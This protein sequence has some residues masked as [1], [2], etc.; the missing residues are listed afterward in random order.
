MSRRDDK[1]EKLED[2]ISD[3]EDEVYN[4]MQGTFTFTTERKAYLL[5]QIYSRKIK[6]EK[7]ED[8]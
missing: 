3:L 4:C 8:A 6:L 1:I 7:L 5:E 2:E